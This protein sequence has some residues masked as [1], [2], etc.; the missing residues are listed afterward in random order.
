MSMVLYG[1]TRWIGVRHYLIQS[2]SLY[3]GLP[4][5]RMKVALAVVM[6]ANTSYVVMVDMRF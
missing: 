6:V 3:F 5:I 4:T 1:I 2:R